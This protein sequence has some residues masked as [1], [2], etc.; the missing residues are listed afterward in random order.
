MLFTIETKDP[1]PFL[2]SILYPVIGGPLFVAGFVHLSS[3]LIGAISTALSS[4]GGFGTMFSGGVDED[5]GVA[6]ASADDSL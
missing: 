2:T 6:T 1:L 4:V 5:D 3:I